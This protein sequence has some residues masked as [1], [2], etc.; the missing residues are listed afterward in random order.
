MKGLF[1]SSVIVL[2]STALVGCAKEPITCMQRVN[3]QTVITEGS[4]DYSSYSLEEQEKQAAQQAFEAACERAT[5][6]NCKGVK[7]PEVASE[8]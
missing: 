6:Y 4:C 2:S 5:N 1:I 7:P 3:G 8:E